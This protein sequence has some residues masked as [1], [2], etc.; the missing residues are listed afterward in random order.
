M[1]R[2][3]MKGSLRPQTTP[4]MQAMPMTQ[5]AAPSTTLSARVLVAPPL[6][7]GSRMPNA[8]RISCE[9]GGLP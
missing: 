2:A 4:A 1:T 3:T 9:R 7:V 8:P 6:T 5:N